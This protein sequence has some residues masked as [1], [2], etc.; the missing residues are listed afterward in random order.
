MGSCPKG[1]F[2][3]RN[4]YKLGLLKTM[5][6]VTLEI[7]GVFNTFKVMLILIKVSF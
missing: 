1:R 5:V 2:S 3:D 6:F 4:K 7:S